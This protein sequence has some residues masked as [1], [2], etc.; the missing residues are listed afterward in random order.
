MQ[1]KECRRKKK[2]VWIVISLWLMVITGC[3]KTEKVYLS[4]EEETEAAERVEQ[5]V[6]QDTEQEKAEQDTECAV[7]VC[8]AVVT[9]GVYV[10][11]GGSRICEA[12][13]AAG[14]MQENAAYES[15]NQAEEIHDG[16]MIVVLTEEE[17]QNEQVQKDDTQKSDTADGRVDLNT[18]TKTQLMTLPGVRRSESGQYHCIPGEKRRFFFDRRYQK[19]RGHQRRCLFKNQRQYRSQ[20]RWEKWRR[21]FL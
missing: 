8:G 13:A 3:G 12:V 15:L 4:T 10:L 1:T 9:P 7:Y 17:M 21:K 18:A 19:N 5:S 16:Q 20:L 14:G 2:T 6:G 11:P